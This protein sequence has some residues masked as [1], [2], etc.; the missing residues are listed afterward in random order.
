[1]K[2]ARLHG[3]H[4]LRLHDEPDPEA[5]AAGRAMM[6]VHSI[7]VCGS[8]L[9]WFAESGIGDARLARPLILGHEF[10]GVALTGKYKGQRVAVDPAVACGECEFCVEGNPN[11][12]INMHFAGHGADDGAMRECMTWPEHLMYPLPDSISDADGAMLEPLGVAIH[13]VDL[14]HIRPGMTVAVLGAGPIGLLTLQMARLA[15]AAE[16]FV[17]DVLPHRMDAAKKYG[18]TTVLKADGTEAAQILAATH[19]RGVDVVLECAGE[20][21]AVEAA[22]AAAKPG[23]T[24]VL[25]GIPSDDRTSFTASVARRKGLTIRMSRRM[26]HT[27][28]RA[29][30]LVERGMVDVR[31]MV[32][33]HYPL[34][35][36]MQ[37]FDAALR[38]DG[39]KIVVEP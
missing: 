21:E 23:G 8:D 34:V 15:G 29:I 20:N 31:S 1:M 2:V 5:P 6:R 16:L 13:A 26:K 30:K 9:H 24:V 19:K 7:G 36:S 35:E 22:V 4:D 39:L 11:F 12:C 25:V 28:P 32:T 18:A 17:T 14:A 38:R 3:V 10:A 33:H 27:Y 37:A